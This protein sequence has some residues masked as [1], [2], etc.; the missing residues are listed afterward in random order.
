MKKAISIIVV[1]CALL[2]IA[3]SFLPDS[4][5]Q[6]FYGWA[7]D[8]E[9]SFSGLNQYHADIGDMTISYYS[10]EAVFDDKTEKPV[11]LMLHGYSA[12][13]DVWVRFARHVMDQYQV[14]IP[15]M[16]GHGDTG[17][18]EKW[19]Y[20]VTAQAERMQ[21]LLDTLNIK[22]VHVIG[23]S[24][25][26][27]I[28][29]HFALNYP[30]RTSSAIL[31]DPAGVRSPTKSDMELML[32]QGRNPFEVSNKEEFKEFFAMSMAKPPWLPEFV[33]RAVSQTYIERKL[34]LRQIFSDL[35]N[36]DMLDN[37]L[38]QINVPILLLWGDQDRLIHVSSVDVWKA[39]VPDIETHIFEGIGH[40]PMLEVPKDSATR[41]KKFIAEKS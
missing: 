21:R 13:K 36:K 37:M 31:V 23:N 22:R 38:S 5:A 10:N 3:P 2:Y 16:A 19:N 27:L 11:I 6:S 32:E 18:D 24:M 30:Q 9:A 7:T 1:A 17:F 14:V 20:R 28:A 34:E 4:T 39:G 25:G 40:V 35:Y 26:G 33:L 8:T 15:D 12:D 41:V 29:A